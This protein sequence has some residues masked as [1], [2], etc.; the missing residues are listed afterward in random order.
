MY[1]E[2]AHL[3]NL[4]VILF[5]WLHSWYIHEKFKKK[6]TNFN[7]FVFKVNCLKPP[8]AHVFLTF[9]IWQ[10]WH[11]KDSAVVF[12]PQLSLESCTFSGIRNLWFPWVVFLF[13][14]IPAHMVSHDSCVITFPHRGGWLVVWT[15][16]RHFNPFCAKRTI[17]WRS[18]MY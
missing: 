7:P 6:P 9:K 3:F 15:D 18:Y 1:S 2:D 14:W 11:H 4:K 8:F 5:I 12:S 13:L 17:T 16:M 10:Y